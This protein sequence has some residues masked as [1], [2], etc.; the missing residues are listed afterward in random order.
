MPSQSLTT[1][2]CIA[3]GVNESHL[4]YYNGRDVH[5]EIVDDLA[6]L[7]RAAKQAGFEFYIA[8]AFRS[9]DKQKS[10]WEHKF[11]GRRPV[12][13]LNNQEVDLST[14]S[15][16]DKVKAIML[17]SALPGA[18]RH[19][20]GSDLDVYA[21]DRLPA[22]QS[23]QLEPWEYLEGGHQYEFSCW[24][25]NSLEHYGF[26]RP[27]D[28][29]RGGVAAEPW[30]ISHWRTAKQLAALQSPTTLEAL[31]ARTNIAGKTAILNNLEALHQQFIANVAP[32]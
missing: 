15:E 11:A 1:A 6:A 31:L 13:D 8:S 30:H 29:F 18:S 28:R 3:C 16:I 25:D 9:F 22:N 17:F 14:L 24:L 21:K 32:L 19:H 27:Y 26:Y 7:V 4:T 5:R 2:Q 10:I 23:L 12:L 20:F